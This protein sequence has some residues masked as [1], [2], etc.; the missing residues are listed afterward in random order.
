MTKAVVKAMDA[1]T[2][3]TKN[4]GVANLEKFMVSGASKR[5]WISWL[6][7]SFFF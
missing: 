2:E 7:V 1:S 3:F 5:G 4:L 6:T